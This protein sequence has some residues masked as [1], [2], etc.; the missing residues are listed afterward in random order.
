MSSSGSNIDFMVP[1]GEGRISPSIDNIPK[2][3]NMAENHLHRQFPSI[4]SGIR[5]TNPDPHV[6]KIH[7][8]LEGR[9]LIRSASSDPKFF[10]ALLDISRQISSVKRESDAGGY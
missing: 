3:I 4:G 6:T 2:A 10:D 1:I 9:F 7:L 5:L 8:H